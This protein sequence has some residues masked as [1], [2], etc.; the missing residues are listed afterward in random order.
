MTDQ[1]SNAQKVR[2]YFHSQYVVQDTPPDVLLGQFMDPD[3]VIEVEGGEP[4]YLPTLLSAIPPI[5]SIPN[6]YRQFEIYDEREDGDRVLFRTRLTLRNPK[7]EK[8]AVYEY[9]QI[10]R[11]NAEGRMFH[12]WQEAAAGTMG[13]DFREILIALG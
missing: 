10:W 12:G 4:L 11:F 8:V 6:E 9:D 13:D 5:R 3:V 1:I 2:N 7:T